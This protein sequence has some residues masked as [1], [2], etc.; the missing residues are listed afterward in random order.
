MIVWLVVLSFGALGLALM[1][2]RKTFAHW[3]GMFFGARMPAGCVL[4]EGALL[5]LGALTFYLLYWLQI[6]PLRRL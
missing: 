6:I 3:Q 5:L 2:W 4:V 1:I